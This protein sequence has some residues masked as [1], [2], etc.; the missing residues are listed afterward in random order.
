V[1]AYID[2]GQHTRDITGETFDFRNHKSA[3]PVLDRGL[4]LPPGSP[5]WDK[6]RLWDEVD[7]AEIARTHLARTGEVRLRANAQLAK[8][9]VYALPRDEQVTDAQRIEMAKL[10]IKEQFTD[11]GLPA[12]WAIHMQEGNP[13]LHVLVPT[14]RLGPEGL[15]KTKATDLN[16]E[17]A[18]GPNGKAYVSEQDYVSEKWEAFQNRY[19]EEQG[20]DLRVDP[21]GVVPQ[22]HEGKA[23]HI[24]GSWKQAENEARL[25][26][27]QQT[28]KVEPETVLERL[29]DKQTTFTERDL[30]RL[31]KK[32]G[33]DDMAEREA[34]KQQALSH[35]EC[36]KLYDANGQETGLYS[37]EAVRREE[38]QVMDRATKIMGRAGGQV[39]DQARNQALKSKTL[40]PEQREAFDVMTARNRLCVIQGRAGAGKSYTMGAAR[41]AFEADGWRVVGLAPTNTVSRDMQKDGFKEASTVHS[42]LLRQEGR[43]TNPRSRT[44]AW[45][46]KTVVFV[47]EAAML[48][49]RTLNRLLEQVEQSG[50]KV[51]MVG[52]D[53][54]LAS[55]Q[56][57]GMYTEIR[58]KSDQA[59]IS[60][61]RRQE[62]DWMKQASMNLADGKV[63]EAI[64]LY[65]EHGCIKG[66][67]KPVEALLSEWKRD[68]ARNPDANRFIYAGTNAEVNRIN[69]ECSRTLREMGKVQEG[70][71]YECKKGVLEFKQTIGVGDRIQFNA[72]AKNIDSNLINGNFGTVERASLDS[73]KVKLDS[74]ASV[75]FNPKEFNGFALG[76]SGTVYKGQ[77][78]TQTDVYALHGSSW[79]KRTTYVGATRHKGEFNLYVDTNKIKSFGQLTRN[80]SQGQ[81]RPSTL[82]YLDEKQAQD[83]QAEIAAKA[84]PQKQAQPEVRQ[85]AA[86]A[87][88]VT[89]EDLQK[90]FDEIMAR[91]SVKHS[92]EPVQERRPQVASETKQAETAAPQIKPQEQPQARPEMAPGA[93]ERQTTSTV[94]ET[95]RAPQQP[96][97][98]GREALEQVR[99]AGRAVREEAERKTQSIPQAIQAGK[100]YLAA[101]ANVESL[102]G[103]VKSIAE[104][105]LESVKAAGRLNRAVKTLDGATKNLDSAVKSAVK[106]YGVKAVKGAMVAALGPPAQIVFAAAKVLQTLD[107]GLKMMR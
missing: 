13:H 69:E 25:A 90:K 48:D 79:N 3:E 28:A 12:Q 2:R 68:V 10:H 74:G 87:P 47:D 107:K 51:V 37:T 26:D 64:Q 101:K 103:Q 93:T 42:E 100:E 38:R 52:D 15:A 43:R 36:V 14:R 49:N 7:K 97:R 31:L 29:T 23:R 21:R 88:K 62:Q 66:S 94:R 40:D 106:D 86:A 82:N 61:V 84:R 35:P 85:E 46:S 8:H 54:Q 33:L 58:H 96:Q 24:E 18:R 60:Q 11:N 19:F 80:M 16:P 32:A 98:E 92:Q 57:G 105:S 55:I 72:T 75:S 91:I 99:G 22:I 67:D 83:R 44:K 71:A 5:Q 78:K 39:S 30:N 95:S 65:K 102:K 59:L 63:H 41:E 53:A 77:G 6:Q 17:F 9:Y 76:Y 27:A 4:E 45:D 70:I 56:R 73:I 50:A 20:L 104:G 89:M 34:A 81:E 1:S